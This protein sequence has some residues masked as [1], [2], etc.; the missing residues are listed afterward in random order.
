MDLGLTEAQELLKTTAANFIQQEYPKETIIALEPTPTGV[1]PELFRKVA[2]LGWLGIVI[3][4]TYGGE[5]HSFTDA[6]VLFEELGRGPVPGPYF[7]SGVL[8]ALTMLH[9]GTEAQKQAILPPVARGERVLCVA[10]TEA[11]YGWRPEKLH[12]HASL[13][14]GHYVLN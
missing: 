4:E 14:H 9:G 7:S 13:Q 5:G 10:V 1:T 11:D 2:E 3:P 8:G 6:A 12:M